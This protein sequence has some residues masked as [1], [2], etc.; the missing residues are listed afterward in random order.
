MRG[1]KEAE[2]GGRRDQ[3]VARGKN[4][5]AGTA[6]CSDVC[7]KGV[8]VVERRKVMKTFVEGGVGGK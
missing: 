5:R 1:K 6:P 8:M 2:K 3:I 4:K 7:T